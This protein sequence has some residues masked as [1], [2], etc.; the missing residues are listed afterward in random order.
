MGALHG[1]HAGISL[2]LHGGVL[3]AVL[4]K[5]LDLHDHCA[6]LGLLVEA[7]YEV[8]VASDRDLFARPRH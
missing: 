3:F 8:I 1:R 6:Q 4:G 2:D 5:D 7:V